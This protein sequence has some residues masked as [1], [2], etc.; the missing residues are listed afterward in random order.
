M[1]KLVSVCAVTAAL[2]VGA[3]CSKKR[4]EECDA[5]VAT[6]EKIAKCDKLPEDQRKTVAESA[7]TIKDAL[8][9][10]DDAGGVGDAPQDL[11]KQLRDTCKTQDVQVTDT[12][13]K[14]QPDCVK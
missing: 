12:F 11:V 13:K 8:K 14:L 7:K 4:V 10:I 6:V 5:F 2:I 1:N 9:M 3:G